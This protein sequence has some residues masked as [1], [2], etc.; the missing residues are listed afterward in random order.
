LNI[1]SWLALYRLVQAPLLNV[2][3]SIKPPIA[4]RPV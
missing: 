1:S 2:L 4:R 3:A